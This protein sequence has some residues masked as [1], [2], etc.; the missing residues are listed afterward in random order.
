MTYI[1]LYRCRNLPTFYRMENYNWNIGLDEVEPNEINLKSFEI[2]DELNPYIWHDN[3]IDSEVR[4]K[5]LE[6]AEDFFDAL[7]IRW[8]KPLDIVI[9]GSLANYNWSKYS[10]IDLHIVLNYD[11]V[12][13]KTEFVEDYFKTKRDMWAST[14]EDLKIYGFP[15]EVYVEDAKNGSKSSGVY[16]LISNE[17][18]AEPEDMNDSGLNKSYIRE[19]SAEVINKIDEIEEKLS[20]DIDDDQMNKLSE[21][22]YRIFEELK[23]LRKKGLESSGQEMSNGNIIWKVIRRAGYIDKL[24]DIIDSTYDKINSIY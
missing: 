17:W 7:T 5:L 11:D 6:I 15:V 14:H 10:D 3:K 4:V 8:V 12:Y 2:R 21:K 18:L 13:E 19:K 20:S 24:W 23:E 1:Y 9:T 22:A 16:S